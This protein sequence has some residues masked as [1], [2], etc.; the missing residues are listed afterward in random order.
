M[1]LVSSEVSAGDVITATE[2]N[3]LRKDV[4]VNAGDFST[5]VGAVNAYDIVIDDQITTLIA[6]QLAKFNPGTANTGASTLRFRNTLALDLTDNVKLP[7]GSNPKAGDIQGSSYCMFDGTDWILLNPGS[8]GIGGNIDI[9]TAGETIAVNEFLYYDKTDNEWKLGDA[10]DTSKVRI[11]AIA[12]TAGTN[13]NP[14]TVQLD[15]IYNAPSGT[16]FTAESMHYASDTPGAASVT[17]STTTSIPF[18]FAPTTTQIV[19]MWGMKMATGLGTSQVATVSQTITIGFR[20]E[21]LI[22]MGVADAGVNDFEK[23]VIHY[24]GGVAGG[25]F[26]YEDLASI[27]S[28]RIGITISKSGNT[29]SAS[30]FTDTTFD[31]D[32]VVAGGPG[33]N[34]IRWMAFGN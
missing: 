16:P 4:L 8:A 6:G 7:D 25:G 30:T 29:L 18:G 3:N 10:N 19:L 12:L 28:G 15:G 1:T 11:R 17:P 21:H 23:G 5:D 24:V 13:G 22:L 27:D 34:N 33:T 32:S 14:M 31:I 2:R 20:A 26:L 9:V